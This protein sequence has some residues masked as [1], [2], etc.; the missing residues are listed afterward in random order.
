[1]KTKDKHDQSNNC[2]QLKIVSFAATK[3]LWT[4]KW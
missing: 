4:A 2:K 1:M 3:Y